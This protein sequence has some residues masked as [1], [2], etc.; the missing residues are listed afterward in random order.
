M[1]EE[2][3]EGIAPVHLG[4]HGQER[5]RLLAARTAVLEPN[6]CGRE[7]ALISNFNQLKALKMIF[8]QIRTSSRKNTAYLIGDE[9]SGDMAVVDIG[10]RP[11]RILERVDALG[12]R[13]KYM[14]A[15]HGHRDHIGKAEAIAR[16]REKTGTRLAAFKTVKDLVLDDVPLDDGDLLEFGRIRVKVIHT[17]GHTDDSVCFLVDGKRLLTGDTLFV[18]RVSTGRRMRAFHDSLHQRILTLPGHIEVWPG[19][20]VGAD[21]SSTIAR[22]RRTNAVL[23]MDYRDFCRRR[24]NGER[25]EV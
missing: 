16:I 14:L 17:L 6:A 9:E 25:C 24:W 20:D 13:L 22:E 15:T 1:A 4:I 11:D 23:K 2:E 7:C 19:H 5:G 21:P 8:E 12:G 10:H 18:G 3:E